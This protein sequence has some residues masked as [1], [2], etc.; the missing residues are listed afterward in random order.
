MVVRSREHTPQRLGLTMFTVYPYRPVVLPAFSEAA[1]AE[2]YWAEVA[3]FTVWD[4]ATISVGYL[5]DGDNISQKL[6]PELIW[7]VHSNAFTLCRLYRAI[8]CNT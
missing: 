4:G 7:E 2:A 8:A 6:G 3:S 1:R 5:S